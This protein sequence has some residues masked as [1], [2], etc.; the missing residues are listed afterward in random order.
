MRTHNTQ[1]HNRHSFVQISAVNSSTIILGLIH[2]EAQKYLK[3]INCSKWQRL[4]EFNI[5]QQR[6]KLSHSITKQR[7]PTTDKG[8]RRGKAKRND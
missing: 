8:L 3:E 6:G 1:V 4:I 2:F 7:R 5:R